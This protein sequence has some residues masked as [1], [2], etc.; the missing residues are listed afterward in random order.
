MHPSTAER[1][2]KNRAIGGEARCVLCQD[3][4]RAGFFL[5]VDAGAPPESRGE[6]TEEEEQKNGGTVRAT[7]GG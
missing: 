4:Q 3:L 5:L 7:D 1:K 2:I 6:G